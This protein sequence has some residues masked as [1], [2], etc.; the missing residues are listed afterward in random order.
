MPEIIPW[1]SDVVQ[2]PVKFVRAFGAVF[3]STSN[4]NTVRGKA[5]ILHNRM[6][7]DTSG[8]S[9]AVV[10]TVTDGEKI[11]YLTC[12]AYGDVGADPGADP[13]KQG[14]PTFVVAGRAF[15]EDAGEDTEFI[16]TSNDGNRWSRTRNGPGN[17]VYVMGWNNTEKKFYAQS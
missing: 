5:A 16:L 9:W 17:E 6:E 1:H 12:G 14:T 7:S 3:V 8:Q 4:P 15:D 11:T 13:P 2:R 10:F